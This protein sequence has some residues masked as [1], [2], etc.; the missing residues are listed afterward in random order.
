MLPRGRRQP[1]QPGDSEQARDQH[2]G[3]ENDCPGGQMG[4]PLPQRPRQTSGGARRAAFRPAAEQLL[5][6]A[7][8]QAGQQQEEGRGSGPGESCP[9]GAWQR[10][11]EQEQQGGPGRHEEQS[12]KGQQGRS[13]RQ[14]HATSI[15]Q[16][17]AGGARSNQIFD[18][19]RHPLPSLAQGASEPCK[20]Q[21]NATSKSQPNPSTATAAS[22][23]RN[24]PLSRRSG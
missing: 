14:D 22:S 11:R 24:R 2:D 12:R 6:G 19:R 23:E 10:P 5:A 7:A 1:A 21:Q 16:D 18:F 4:E 17:F 3:A 8:P 20:F 15:I 9:R 13:I